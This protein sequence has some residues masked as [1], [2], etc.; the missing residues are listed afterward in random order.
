MRKARGFVLAALLCGLVIGGCGDSDGTDFAAIEQAL[1]ECSESAMANM[2]LAFYGLVNIPDVIAGEDPLPGLDV[3]VNVTGNPL[4]WDFLIAFDTPP[5]DMLKYRC[6]GSRGSM[7][8]E[9]SFGPSGV[10]SC[11]DP[12]HSRYCGSSLMLEYGAQVTP[13]SSERNRPWGDVPAY[14]TLGS[15]ECAGVSQNV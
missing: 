15:F 2:M 11:S 1:A 4:V 13:P 10:P 5:L 8:I 7:M 6:A 9:C 3:N 12:I 14:Q